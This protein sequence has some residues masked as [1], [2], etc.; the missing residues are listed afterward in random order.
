MFKTTFQ[1]K[2]YHLFA[3]ALTR[4]FSADCKLQLDGRRGLA[5]T[6][7]SSPSSDCCLKNVLL[8]KPAA[9]TRVLCFP[10]SIINNSTHISGSA[11]QVRSY[12][13]R[14]RSTFWRETTR[15]RPRGN[16]LTTATTTTT[17]A[18]ARIRAR[19]NAITWARALEW[20]GSLT[21]RWVK[22]YHVK[23]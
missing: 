16:G 23:M 15:L 8:I 3:D 18:A 2:W 14:R 17:T 6:L 12:R 10:H 5:V 11:C 22:F 20:K 4:P 19:T 7:S 9:L 21:I 1:S 13:A